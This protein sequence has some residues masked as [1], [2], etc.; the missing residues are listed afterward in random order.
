MLNSPLRLLCILLSLP[1][2]LSACSNIKPDPDDKNAWPVERYAAEAQKQMDK[3]NWDQAIELYRELE[4][5]YP[6]GK[7]AE[8]AQINT[9][10]THY[11]SGKPELAL[12]DTERFIRLHPTH[13]R[14]DYAYYLRGLVSFVEDNTILGKFSGAD[15][16][17]DRDPQ[18]ARNAYEAF[19][20]L[21]SRFPDSRYSA[22][23]L[24]RMVYL[25]SALARHDV[26]VA[27]FYMDRGAYVAVVNRAKYVIENYQETPAVEDALGL[28]MQAY[29]EMG[30]ETL[31]KDTA[32]VLARNFP[33]TKYL[34]TTK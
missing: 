27:Q 25:F 20:E 13:P 6:Y 31:A 9:A 23:A 15:D 10:Y 12:L 29:A 17:S 7:Y 16:L 8:Q 11:K 24:Q 28:M 4:S 30:M 32:R 21:V 2:L 22:D 34:A 5:K 1:F 3:K 26:G 19:R 14:V 33:D 18:A